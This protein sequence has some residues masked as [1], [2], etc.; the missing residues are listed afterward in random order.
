MEKGVVLAIILGAVALASAQDAGGNGR[1][2]AFTPADLAQAEKGNEFLE[3][4]A[5]FPGKESFSEFAERVTELVE[6]GLEGNLTLSDVIDTIKALLNTLNTMIPIMEKGDAPKDKIE[7]AKKIRKGFQDVL[8][9]LKNDL[10][11]GGTTT[12]PPPPP[13]PPPPTS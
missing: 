1:F 8:E 13:P 6:E 4:L 11:N 12:T 10:K 3:G 2:G 9:D 7:E 5:D